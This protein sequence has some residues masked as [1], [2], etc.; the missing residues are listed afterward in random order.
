M[1]QGML[2]PTGSH[3]G[4]RVFLGRAGGVA[5]DGARAAR[6]SRPR[7]PAPRRQPRV[8]IAC[9]ETAVERRQRRC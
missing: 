3:A 1:A 6:V 4:G 7:P 2:Q 8:R 9:R 5:G